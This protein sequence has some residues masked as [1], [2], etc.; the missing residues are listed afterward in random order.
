M[1]AGQVYSKRKEAIVACSLLSNIS[2]NNNCIIPDD[3]TEPLIVWIYCVESQCLFK[4]SRHIE[5][6]N[7]SQS[8]FKQFIYIY[9]QYF[10]I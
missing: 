8:N 2:L 3:P 9:D 6:S 7:Q 5:K 4:L 1:S 10:I